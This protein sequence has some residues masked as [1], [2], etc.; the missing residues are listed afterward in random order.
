[1]SNKVLINSLPFNYLQFPPS[2]Q[3]VFI[4]RS[5]DKFITKKKIKQGFFLKGEFSFL[6][7]T[8]NFRFSRI[9]KGVEP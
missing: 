6:I 2:P 1:M 9:C 8:Y 3:Q 7:T 4:L 5:E